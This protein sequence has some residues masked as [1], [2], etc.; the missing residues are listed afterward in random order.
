MIKKKTIILFCLILKMNKCNCIGCNCIK[1]NS[2]ETIDKTVLCEQTKLRLSEI[3]KLFLS[4][5]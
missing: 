5:N 1:N 2:L 4:R 3:N